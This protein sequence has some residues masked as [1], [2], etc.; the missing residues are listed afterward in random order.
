MGHDYE[1]AAPRRGKGLKVVQ[2]L[3]A[4]AFGVGVLWA[5]VVGFGEWPL[6]GVALTVLG[7]V[8]FVGTRAVQ[9]WRQP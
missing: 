8:V 9:W 6:E 3:A 4:V 5:V 7:L 2:G 1:L